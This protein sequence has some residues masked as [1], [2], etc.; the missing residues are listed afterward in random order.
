MR[1]PKLRCQH[2]NRAFAEWP[3]SGR[4]REYFGI[5]GTPEAESAYRQWVAQLIAGAPAEPR[6]TAVLVRDFLPRYLDHVESY[7]RKHGK[8][9]KEAGL[10]RDALRVLHALHSGTPMADFGPVQLTQ[11]QA[12]LVDRGYTRGTVNKHVSRVRR[13]FRWCCQ[14]GHAP[15][16][17][18]HNLQSVPGLRAGRTAAKESSPVL[19][20][21]W[22]HV[23]QTLP[24]VSPT[25]RAM[26]LVQFYCGMRPQD[27]TAMRASE[28]DVSGKIW[29]YR[30]RSHK[31]EHHGA[32]L[33][34]AV[35]VVAQEVIKPFFVPDINAYLFRPADSHQWHAEQRRANRNRKT[36]VYPSEARRRRNKPSHKL[37]ACY[38]TDS[39]R[40][41]INHGLTKAAKAGVEIPHW[42]PHQLRHAVATEIAKTFGQQ[43]AQRWLGHASLDTTS[44]YAE[45]EV[46]ELVTI[47][48]QLDRHWT[49]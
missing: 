31:T 10:I 40:R 49:A 3:K 43:A 35:P 32:K 41:A 25:I 17:L 38:D 12:V 20:V 19:P 23:E 46:D 8:P 36:P 42:H 24:F 13:F 27:V 1:I 39:Y 18:Y 9:T 28:L 29:L 15:P 22:P 7:Y 47:A 16:E 5:Y 33:V 30:P 21:P 26:I 34:K 4:K 37:R 6:K 14:N 45:R 44:I 2:P 48:N 11:V